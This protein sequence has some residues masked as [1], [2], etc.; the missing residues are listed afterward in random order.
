MLFRHDLLKE[1]MPKTIQE[2]ENKIA[3][4]PAK[5]GEI[6]TTEEICD[7]VRAVVRNEWV[8]FNK[9]LV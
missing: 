2:L 5:S 4:F 8:V 9:I 1:F 3:K 6:Y 7:I